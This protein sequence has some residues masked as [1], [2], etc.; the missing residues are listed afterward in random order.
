MNLFSFWAGIKIPLFYCYFYY[1]YEVTEIALESQNE[2][3][4]R[5]FKSLF[6]GRD[7][8]FAIRWERPAR[9]AGWGS[10]NGYMPTYFYVP[11]R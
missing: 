9:S 10:K 8:V 11:Y 6:I 3:P 1:N 2:E 5:L 4:I 7:D